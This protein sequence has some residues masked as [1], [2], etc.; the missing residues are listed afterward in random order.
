MEKG[1]VGPLLGML[2][3]GDT[4]EKEAASMAVW[5]LAFSKENRLTMR[6]YMQGKYLIIIRVLL[7]SHS[8]YENFV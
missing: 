7:T 6:V 2:R 4:F 3:D 1:V 8:V 5:V